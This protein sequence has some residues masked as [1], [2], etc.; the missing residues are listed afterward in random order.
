M[1]PLI[2]PPSVGSPLSATS[3]HRRRLCVDASKPQPTLPSLA[4]HGLPSPRPLPK[5]HMK[6]HLDPDFL[7]MTKDLHGPKPDRFRVNL[8]NCHA[9]ELVAEGFGAMLSAIRASMARID[10]TSAIF[11][12]EMNEAHEVAAYICRVREAANN[13]VDEMLATSAVTIQRMY[14]GSLGRQVYRGMRRMKAAIQLQRIARGRIGRRAYVTKKLQTTVASAV[15]GLRSL[16]KTQHSHGCNDERANQSRRLDNNSTSLLHLIKASIAIQTKWR[17][18][19]N[20]VRRNVGDI[21]TVQ[22]RARRLNRVLVQVSWQ[23]ATMLGILRF[24]RKATALHLV[25]KPAAL[26]RRRSSIE[27]AIHSRR[28]IAAMTSPR[29]DSDQHIEHVID[30]VSFFAQNPKVWYTRHAECEAGNALPAVATFH[31]SLPPPTL[32]PSNAPGKTNVVL[33][34]NTK[35]RSSSLPLTAAQRRTSFFGLV[36]TATSKPPDNSTERTAAKMKAKPSRGA[37]PIAAAKTSPDSS[38]RQRPAFYDAKRRPDDVKRTGGSQTASCA[39]YHEEGLR[40]KAERQRQLEMKVEQR[41]HQRVRR[42]QR[43]RFPPSRRKRASQ[44]SLE[45]AR[46]QVAQAIEATASV[47]AS[48]VPTTPESWVRAAVAIAMQNVLKIQRG[49]PSPA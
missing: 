45:L 43:H 44:A 29:N 37:I 6:P 33:L 42:E 21:Q 11:R 47:G 30:H 5:L 46:A 49:G 40:Q 36:P 13:Q 41:R 31:S 17:V 34:G 38:M 14:R 8:D 2:A 19:Y 39:A 4:L 28:S 16:H 9:P 7:P 20:K 15:L 22:A 27:A 32:S 12:A 24:W 18:A 1:L 3:N 10:A 25:S 26:V 35:A 48:S 23:V